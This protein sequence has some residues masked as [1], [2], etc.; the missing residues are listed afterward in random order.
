MFSQILEKA[1]MGNPITLISS[2]NCQFSMYYNLVDS[3]FRQS[4]DI[5][6]KKNPHC[7]LFSFIVYKTDHITTIS[8]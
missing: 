7:F 5:V 3:L 1:N 6:N 2:E 4:A 8:L